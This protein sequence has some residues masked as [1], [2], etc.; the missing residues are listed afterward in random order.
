MVRDDPELLD[1]GG[2]TPRPQGRGRW[3]DP[4]C[5]ISP[6]LEEKLAMWNIASCALAFA[7]LKINNLNHEEQHH[8]AFRDL[9][10]GF[11]GG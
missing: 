2:E 4:G 5:E 6:P 11:L 9:P 7:C 8:V 1:D 3:F 10:S